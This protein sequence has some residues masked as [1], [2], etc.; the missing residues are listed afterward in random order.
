VVEWSSG[1][2][3]GGGGGFGYITPFMV[4]FFGMGVDMLAIGEGELGGPVERR[5]R[6]EECDDFF[7]VKDSEKSRKW[8]SE[9]GEWED[10][11]AGLL[12]YYKCGCGVFLV[13]LGGRS[14]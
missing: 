3:G 12:Q 10:G 2:G 11:E 5:V 7:P 8:N 14:I 4:A 13:G 9:T 1:G 6:C